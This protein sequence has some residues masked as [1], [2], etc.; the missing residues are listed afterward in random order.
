MS[1]QFDPYN[2]RYVCSESNPLLCVRWWVHKRKFKCHDVVA[3]LSCERVMT[4]NK[5]TYK[6]EQRLKK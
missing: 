1:R 5:S 3:F 6:P 2:D 4:A